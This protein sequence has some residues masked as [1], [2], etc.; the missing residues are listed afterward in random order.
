METIKLTPN[1]EYIGVVLPKNSSNINR[2]RRNDGQYFL[3]FSREITI[4]NKPWVEF[5]SIDIPSQFWIIGI[6]GETL[7]EKHLN[8]IYPNPDEF[9]QNTMAGFIKEMRWKGVE[10]ENE[11]GSHPDTWEY[12]FEAMHKKPE[13]IKLWESSE[14]EIKK[15]VVIKCKV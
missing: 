10:T 4:L 7:T 2:E 9:K 6:L 13:D 14:R 12:V 3:S 5:F 15:V 8:E 11:Y 1:G